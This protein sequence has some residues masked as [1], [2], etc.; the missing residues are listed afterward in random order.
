MP[1]DD[2]ERWKYLTAAAP[3]LHTTQANVRAM[4]ARLC[5]EYADELRKSG[6]LSK[7]PSLALKWDECLTIAASYLDTQEG[8]LKS[9]LD[10]Y[11][12]AL[13][14]QTNPASKYGIDFKRKERGMHIFHEYIHD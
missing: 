1:S 6:F 8:T 3:T 5:V 13:H 4:I 9:A 2:E 11:F 7:N 12:Y 10:R 14:A